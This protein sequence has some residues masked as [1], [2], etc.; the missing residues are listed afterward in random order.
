VVLCEVLS[1]DSS[2]RVGFFCHDVDKS[3]IR[4]SINFELYQRG[5]ESEA[6]LVGRWL[7]RAC[8]TSGVDHTL[9]LWKPVAMLGYDKFS[10]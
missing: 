8:M 3:H 2:N 6:V 7:F 5:S 1:L 10:R 9:L 4:K